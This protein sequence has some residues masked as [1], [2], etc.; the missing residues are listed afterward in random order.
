VTTFR[1]WENLAAYRWSLTK[2]SS[3]AELEMNNNYSGRIRAKGYL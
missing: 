2:I 1:S 3:V